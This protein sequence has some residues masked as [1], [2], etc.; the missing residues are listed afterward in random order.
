MIRRFWLFGSVL[1]NDFA[2][3]SDVDVLV[4]FQPGASWSLF[5]L[6]DME[7]ELE[8]WFGRPVDLVDVEALSN[9]IRRAHILTQG[10]F[11]H[12]AP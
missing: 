9:P 6:G 8:G 7:E 5:H 1:G 4:Q 10:K 2:P 3:S 12:E 11:V